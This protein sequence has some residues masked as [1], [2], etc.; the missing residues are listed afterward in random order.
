MHV[1]LHIVPFC[2]QII[3]LRTI[4]QIRVTPNLKSTH[5]ICA[6]RNSLENKNYW[7]T[8]NLT[9]VKWM[10]ISNIVAKRLV[11]HKGRNLKDIQLVSK[12]CAMGITVKTLTVNETDEL[13]VIFNWGL[14]LFRYQNVKISHIKC[15][16]WSDTLLIERRRALFFYFDLCV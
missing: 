6:M 1:K 11:Q 4:I 3:R 13:L 8:L 10:L 12:C 7:F 5:V 14:L 16:P 2:S 15:A 9:T